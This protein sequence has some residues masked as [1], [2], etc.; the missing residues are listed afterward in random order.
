MTGGYLQG[1]LDIIRREAT[2]ARGLCW[3]SKNRQYAQL[4]R[5]AERHI[6]ACGAC[7]EDYADAISRELADL[8]RL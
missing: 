6:E 4:K 8:M 7:W 1:G 2:A 3:F 5:A